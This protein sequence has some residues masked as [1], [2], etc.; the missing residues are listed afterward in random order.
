MNMVKKILF[1]GFIFLSSLSTVLLEAAARQWP[2]AVTRCTANDD[3]RIKRKIEHLQSIG[4]DAT[5]I[6]HTDVALDACLANPV[7]SL[8]PGLT[9]NLEEQ[10]K[11]KLQKQKSICEQCGKCVQSAATCVAACAKFG[12]KHPSTCACIVGAGCLCYAGCIAAHPVEALIDARNY[13]ALQELCAASGCVCMMSGIFS[14]HKAIKEMFFGKDD[15]KQR[16]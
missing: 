4:V 5:G 7:I 3:L 6:E 16:P 15:K 12:C 9:P 13:G 1:T 2:Y 14:V 8:Q 11:Q 10:K